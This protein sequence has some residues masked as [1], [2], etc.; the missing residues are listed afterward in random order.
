MDDCF[1]LFY[2]LCNAL[3]CQVFWSRLYLNT[4]MFL[5]GASEQAHVSRAHTPLSPDSSCVHSLHTRQQALAVCP[6]EPGEPCSSQISLHWVWCCELV[7]WEASSL[8]AVTME[9]GTPS[10]FSVWENHC[11]MCYA[12]RNMLYQVCWSWFGAL[13]HFLISK[14]HGSS[15]ECHGHLW[16]GEHDAYRV[17]WIGTKLGFYKKCILFT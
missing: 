14:R 8:G 13:F 5:P 7:N 1:H 4:G 9:T 6:Q 16:N 17:L 11:Q 15:G 10:R 2:G 12:A 3:L